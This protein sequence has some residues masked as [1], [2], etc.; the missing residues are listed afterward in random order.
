L[1][2]AERSAAA[3][4]S[5]LGFQLFGVDPGERLP[6]GHRAVEVDID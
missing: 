2:S 3:G 1:A 6:N 5:G 4:L